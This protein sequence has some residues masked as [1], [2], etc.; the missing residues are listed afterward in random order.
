MAQSRHVCLHSNLLE[1]TEE[2]RRIGLQAL[3]TRAENSIAFRV[4]LELVLTKQARSDRWTSLRS[5][6][7]RLHSGL[8]AGLDILDLEI[9]AVSDDRDLLDTKS[10]FGRLRRRGQ[11]AQIEDLVRDLLLDDQLV[12]GVH[13]DLDVVT[14]CDVRVRRHGPAVRDPVEVTVDVELQ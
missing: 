1:S 9:P 2:R 12:L 11:Q 4:V 3:A 8:L 14:D 7:I 6:H 10:L 5:R 13:R